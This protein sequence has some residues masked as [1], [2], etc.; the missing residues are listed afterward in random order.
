MELPI[1]DRAMAG[2][3]LAQLLH[4]YRDQEDV[5]VL[6]LAR[7]GVPVAYEIATDLNLPLDLMLVR[8]LGAPG[9]EQ[10]AMGAIAS[11]GIRVLNDH[12]LRSLTIPKEAV[13]TVASA[14]QRELERQEQVYRGDQSRPE[15]AGKCVILVDDG[16]ATGASVRAGI[17]ALREQNAA[18]IVVAVPVSPP[19]TLEVLRGAADEAVCLATPEP[20]VAIS[21]WYTDFHQVT[22]AEVTRLLGAA[23]AVEHESVSHG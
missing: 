15:I 1:K 22:D 2:R 23:W 12:V 8:K 13:E 19:N 14:E 9:Q 5:L 4:S 7:G 3:A 20:F 18:R 16:V 17:A 10:V 21:R 11:G 6:G